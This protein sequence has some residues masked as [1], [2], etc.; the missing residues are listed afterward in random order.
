MC[1]HPLKAFVV[2]VD[3]DNKKKLKITSYQVDH[4]EQRLGETDSTI[5]CTTQKETLS[6]KNRRIDEFI[7]IP[8]GKCWQCRL[9]YSR[10]WANR[11][12]MELEDHDEAWFL[13]L[14]YD[15]DHVPRSYYADPETG[16]AKE[17]LTLDKRDWVLFMKRLRKEY[18]AKKI[19]FFASGEYGSSTARPHYHAIVYDLHFD[20]NELKFFKKSDGFKLWRSE[21]LDKVWSKGFAVVAEVSWDSC[22][23]VAR[24]VMKKVNGDMAAFY[25]KFGLEPEFCLM[26]RKPGI[27]RE[28]FERNRDRIYEY[29]KVNLSTP[30][31]GISM[32]PPKYFDQLFDQIDH[33][34]M[35]ELKEQR[36]IAAER[37]KAIELAKTDLD[38]IDYLAAKEREAIQNQLTL[39]KRGRTE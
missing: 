5:I 10:N 17:S 7:E 8:C 34:R 28:Y 33:E 27:A 9:A 16:E 35:T 24:Y 1:Y 6:E 31:K 13:T 29:D 38:Y 30:K 19:R 11:L 39:L 23:Y 14:T 20:E 25:D 12:M 18:D 22:A 21:R 37:I 26:S 4:V 15:N 32:K 3:S 2:H 36:K